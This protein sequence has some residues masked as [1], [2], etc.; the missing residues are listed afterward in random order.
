MS[1]AAADAS[2]LEAAQAAVEAQ[3]QAA[4]APCEA[5]VNQ[6]N[7]RLII[8][9]ADGTTLALAP[10]ERRKVAPETVK[11]I[12][13]ELD[14]LKNLNYVSL[15]FPEEAQGEWLPTTLGVGVWVV[16]AAVVA[17]LWLDLGL[18]YWIVAGAVIVLAAIAVWRAAE[19]GAVGR[20][21]S[22]T[23]AL[24]AVLA[25][26]IGLPA[27]VIWFG[28][29]LPDVVDIAI[30][31]TGN[32]QERAILTLLGRALQLLFIA[33]VA[34]LPGLLYFLF[35]RARLATLRERFTRQVFRLD[36]TLQ[37]QADV[38]AKYGPI[39]EETY[40]P[41]ARAGTRLQPGTQWP[42]LLATI[43]LAFGWVLV[44][45]NPAV[46]VVSS[47]DLRTLFRPAQTAP[48]YAFLGGYVFSLT[49][50][51]RGFVRGDLRPKTY[52]YI[53]VR[54]I[55]VIIL[56]WVLEVVIDPGDE[57]L[58]TAFLAGFFPDTVLY[59]LRELSRWLGGK[60]MDP[61][62]LPLGKLDGVDIYERARLESEGITNIQALAKHDLVDLVLQTR[63]PVAR[64]VDWTDQAILHLHAG[65]DEALEVLRRNGICKASDLETN[66]NAAVA[67]GTGNAFRAIL[68]YEPS[69]LP[70]VCGV[71]DAIADEE[72]M[73]SIRYWHD[74]IHTRE[75][76][77]R[78][79][80]SV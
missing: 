55:V 21:L 60:V 39:V 49:A 66:Y 16:L 15:E 9:G 64:L 40:G 13:R 25:A 12:E 74:P 26:G 18:L 78:F 50:V 72:W 10:L 62:R 52:G 79:P 31:G 1:T 67:R 14:A 33:V 58:L 36:R 27:A 65:G 71:I 28:A 46:E 59:R 70:R 48:A 69:R 32:E 3:K 7:R 29:N 11:K 22:L 8:T 2:G 45:L 80:E 73:D 24:V 20:W 4:P 23:T 42:I 5:I 77:I 57:L 47:L 54:I 76:S 37:T 43:V 34:L 56:A 61:D 53:A 75:Q 6:L 38:M 35:D 41:A 44:L 30:N 63:I 51:L 19:S 17:G 68:G